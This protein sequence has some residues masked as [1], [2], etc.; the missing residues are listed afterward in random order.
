MGQKQVPHA[1]YN[2][3]AVGGVFFPFFLGNQLSVYI[4][5]GNSL[6]LGMFVMLNTQLYSLSL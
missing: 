3:R 4:L 6:S 2:G 5:H 1:Q